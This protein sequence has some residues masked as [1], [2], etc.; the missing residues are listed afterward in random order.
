MRCRPRGRHAL[1]D[2]VV[3]T[4]N[5]HQGVCFETAG[6]MLQSSSAQ[7]E[8]NVPAC[9]DALQHNLRLQCLRDTKKSARSAGHINE[10]K[11]KTR[12]QPKVVVEFE[13]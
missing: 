2:E 8:S 1:E 12:W 6:D 3:K 13:V 7:P 4:V 5:R 10:A 11:D 9:F